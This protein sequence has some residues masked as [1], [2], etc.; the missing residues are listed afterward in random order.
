M[1][2]DIEDTKEER[3]SIAMQFVDTLKEQNKRLFLVW[4]ITFIAL[5]SMVVYTIYLLNDIAVVE[6]TEVTQESDTGNINYNNIENG[7]KIINGETND[8]EN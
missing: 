7:G 8:K 5:T 2:K 3:K 6:T 1:R 4:L